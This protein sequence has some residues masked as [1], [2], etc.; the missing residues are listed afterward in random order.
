MTDLV[1]F[2]PRE[3]QL[4][5]DARGLGLVA[6]PGTETEALLVLLWNRGFLVR[7]DEVPFTYRTVDD[8]E[9]MLEEKS[10]G[11]GEA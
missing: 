8:V 9:R 2:T 10:D 3:M 7:D 5:R 11:N 1:N 4:L 6:M